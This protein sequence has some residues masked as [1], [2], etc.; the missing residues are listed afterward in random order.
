VTPAP[1]TTATPV[2]WLFLDHE[3]PEVEI[4][5][6]LERTL[7][8]L[9]WTSHVVVTGPDAEGRIL[10]SV[11][12]HLD[13]EP[14]AIVN[15]HHVAAA[16][17]DRVPPE[18]GRL[19]AAAAR[20]QAA[21]YR[22]RTGSRLVALPILEVAPGS[23]PRPALAVAAGLVD[24]LAKPSL[25]LWRSPD[26]HTIN[27]AA[28]LGLRIYLGIGKDSVV[29]VLTTAHVLDATMDRVEDADTRLDPCRS[30]L[31]ASRGRVF[32]CARQHQRGVARCELGIAPP[33]EW[34]PDPTLCPGCIADVVT[35]SEMSLTANLRRREGRELALRTS[36]AMVDRRLFFSA[37][38]IASTAAHLS[39]TDIQTANALIQ[40]A[41]CHLADDS[42]EDADRALIRAGRMGA[43]P[44]LVAYHRARVQVAWRDDIEALTHFE[45]ALENGTDAVSVEDLHL[46]MALSHIRLEE[47]S[48][49]R[50]HLEQA[51][52]PSP[53]I[54]FNLGVCH[55]NEGRPEEALGHLDRSM[56]LRPS[57][58]DLGR[59]RF[60]RGFC[61]KELERYDEAVS[62]LRRSIELEPP[63]AAHHNLLGFCLFKLKHYSEAVSAFERAVALDPHSAVDWAN[64][65]VNL[66]R[67]GQTDRAVEMYEKALGM[68]SGIGFAREGLDRL[69]G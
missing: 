47:W 20:F 32:G 15:L 12:R 23:D 26:Q 6:W 55:L 11:E 40:V 21:A 58:D 5:A 43:S 1:P 4:A 27:D 48:E 50:S 39:D 60:F 65:G 9:A 68:D 34:R 54:A 69:R 37:A 31:V 29:D 24:E 44:G 18:I 59:V 14:L 49:A 46:E 13:R 63:E 61:L 25:L 51:A 22:E 41:L 10:R 33:A 57:S 67:L 28:R 38:A 64:I 45:E 2:Q 35:S 52:G 30:H 19:M 56:A 42:L 3:I 8:D 66:E 62:D 53:E 7:P 36:A 17:T 16:D